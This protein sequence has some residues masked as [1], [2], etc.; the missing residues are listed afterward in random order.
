[1]VLDAGRRL[2]AAHD[3]D[4][5][6]PGGA[7][8]VGDV[9]RASSAPASSTRRL[10]AELAGQRPVLAQ[11]V[12]ASGAASKWRSSRM[13]APYRSPSFGSRCALIAREPND[14]HDRRRLA[15][16]QL[17]VVERE[18]VGDRR[19]GGRVGVDEHAHAPDA[20]GHPRRELGGRGAR[21]RAGRPVDEDEADQVR[22]GLDGDREVVG[23]VDAA[24]LD[25][26]SSARR[27]PGSAPGRASARCR[28]APRGSRC[29]LMRD[30]VAPRTRCPTRR[31]SGS[32][33]GR[34]AAGAAARPAR[35]SACRG[36]GR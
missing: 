5:P 18:L 25:Q 11:L 8:R 7:D 24:D 32:P 20:V 9:R 36:C 21:D 35:S 6:G 34:P 31:P 2:D 10:G 4:G 23:P 3:V 26:A 27:A 22:A 12:R 16:V 13:V 28:P 30:R 14:S 29:A 15:A 1:M 17:H 19:D 33:A